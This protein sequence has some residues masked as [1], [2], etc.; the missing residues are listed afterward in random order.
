[1]YFTVFLNF[2]ING[3]CNRIKLMTIINYDIFVIYVLHSDLEDR[4]HK[5]HVTFEGG[6][7]SEVPCPEG[8]SSVRVGKKVVIFGLVCLSGLIQC[9]EVT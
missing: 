8:M 4:I 9:I 3:Y 5:S 7:A 2:I 1:M 6:S